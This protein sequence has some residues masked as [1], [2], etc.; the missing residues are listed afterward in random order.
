MGWVMVTGDLE[1]QIRQNGI[2][3]LRNKDNFRFQSIRSQAE[4]YISSYYYALHEREEAINVSIQRE[5]AQVLEQARKDS[6]ER[7]LRENAQVY[8]DSMAFSKRKRFAER[9][10]LYRQSAPIHIQIL[11][12][13]PDHAGGVEI[14]AWIANCTQRTIKYITL[15]GFFLNAVGDKCRDEIHGSTVWQRKGVGPIKPIPE[16]VDY[17]PLSAIFLPNVGQYNFDNPRFY[18]HEVH[19]LKLTKVVI[20]YMDGHVTTLQGKQLDGHVEYPRR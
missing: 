7:V 2:T 4:R 6:V 17:I 15:T 8:A 3:D 18:S 11:G 5:R 9:L 14:P 10:D 12:F 1:K 20:E 19:S 13:R 16:S